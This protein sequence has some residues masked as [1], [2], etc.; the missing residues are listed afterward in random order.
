[1]TLPRQEGASAPVD[2]DHQVRW[3]E[4]ARVRHTCRRVGELK[5][6]SSDTPPIVGSPHAVEPPWTTSVPLRRR[7][8]PLLP[9]SV[10]GSPS[11]LRFS[12][13][14]LDFFEIQRH[15]EVI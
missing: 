13:F 12:P 9:L 8:S 2:P 3:P 10:S 5:G 6:T 11:F 7:K 14:F 1:M 15:E 4:N